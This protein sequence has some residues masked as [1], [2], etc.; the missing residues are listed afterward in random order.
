M[1]TNIVLPEL[2]ESGVEARVAKWLKN[3]GDA[4]SVGEAL[5]ELETEKIDLEVS[6][7]REGVL[8]SIKHREG[9]DV[10][11]GEVLAVLEAGAAAAEAPKPA[12]PSEPAED[13]KPSSRPDTAAALGG[14][15]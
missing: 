5:V 12:A 3:E 2:G 10:K 7:D 8:T 9:A 11:V 13:T 4:V 14:G 15:A 1:E 6:A